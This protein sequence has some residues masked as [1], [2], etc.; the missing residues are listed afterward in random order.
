MLIKFTSVV[1][2]ELKHIVYRAHMQLQHWVVE[3]WTTW[4]TSQIIT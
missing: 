1:G 4:Y 3:G 2:I